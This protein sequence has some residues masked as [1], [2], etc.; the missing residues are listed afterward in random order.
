M[1]V[2]SLAKIEAV[3]NQLDACLRD[4]LAT[5]T[6]EEL[7]LLAEAWMREPSPML[8][9]TLSQGKG[10]VEGLAAMVAIHYYRELLSRFE[11][12]A[13]GDSHNGG[14]L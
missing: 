6:T 2:R 9:R 14:S 11:V 10:G 4:N 7:K 5:Y 12:E 3:K 8:I 1:N 13:M